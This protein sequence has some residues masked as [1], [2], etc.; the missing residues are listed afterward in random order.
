MDLSLIHIWCGHNG[1][2]ADGEHIGKLACGFAQSGHHFGLF[3]GEGDLLLF[4]DHH[5]DEGTY[6]H[7][8]EGQL[9]GDVGLGF[10]NGPIQQQSI[11]KGAQTVDQAIEQ[12]KDD[13]QHLSLIHI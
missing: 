13:G 2:G 8:Q 10:C 9:I 4:D 5:I 6:R 1:V 12:G 3:L 11:G 7:E